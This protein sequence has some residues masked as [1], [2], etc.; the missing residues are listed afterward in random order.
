MSEVIILTGSPGS[1]KT[2]VAPLLAQRYR[3]CVHLRT[4][5]FWHVIVQGAIPPYLPESDQQ[6]HTVVRVIAA[7]AFGYAAGGYTTIVDG[8]VGPWM[9]HHYREVADQHREIGVHYVVLRPDREAA[10]RRAQLRTGPDDLTD[11]QPILDL[12]E[13]FGLLG[14][15]RG[16]AIDTSR[17]DALETT[18]LVY[19]QLA[20]DSMRI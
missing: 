3:R 10:L 4:D 20:S 16:H 11:A 5:D 1:G 13:Q 9:L 7:A 6:N 15:L 19:R 2:T 14:D 8:I 12:W 17:L 18:A